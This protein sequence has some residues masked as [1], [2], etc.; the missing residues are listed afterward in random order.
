MERQTRE[1]YPLTTGVATRSIFRKVAMMKWVALVAGVFLFFNG[2]M[3]RTYG[4]T[5]PPRFC[6]N[7][8]YIG[9][10]GCFASPAGPKVVVWGATLLGLAL[11]V[12]CVLWSRR[13]AN[14]A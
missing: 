1:S 8:D 14:Q 3:S 2:M 5:N 13:G 10:Y 9:L 11:I 12:G 6:W 4:Y 7:M